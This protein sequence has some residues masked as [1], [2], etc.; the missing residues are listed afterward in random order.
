[1]R[2]LIVGLASTASRILSMV[3][4]FRAAAG[5]PISLPRGIMDPVENSLDANRRNVSSFGVR[6]AGYSNA[7]ARAAALASPLFRAYTQNIL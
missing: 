6:I 7:N 5:L 3:P 2:T 4:G 1:M